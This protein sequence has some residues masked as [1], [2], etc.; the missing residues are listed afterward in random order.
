MESMSKRSTTISVKD[1]LF[2]DPKKEWCVEG[3]SMPMT[4]WH[5]VSGTIDK[6]HMP[7]Y[8]SVF[9][10]SKPDLNLNKV[11]LKKKHTG[12]SPAHYK[13]KSFFKSSN[14]GKFG[15]EEKATMTS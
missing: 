8:L 6:D 2:N 4:H 14:M 5:Q 7:K 11:F 15:K 3:Y 10:D 12:P 9:N 13:V 1:F